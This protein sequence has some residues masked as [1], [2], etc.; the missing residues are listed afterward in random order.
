MSLIPYLIH[1]PLLLFFA[2]RVKR[3]YESGP[4]NKYYY[5]ALGLKIGAGIAL[6]FI[7][8]FYYNQPGDTFYLFDRSS[9]LASLFWKDPETFFKIFFFNS[10]YPICN[11]CNEDLIFG[12][13]I[14]KDPRT[15]FY[16]KLLTTVN[17]VSFNNYWV[18]SAYLSFFSFLGFFQLA[19]TLV[20][21]FNISRTAT[22]FSLLFF[23][24]VLIW[25]SGVMKESIVMGSMVFLISIVLRWLYSLEKPALKNLFYLFLFAFFMFKIKYYYFVILAPVLLSFSFVKIIQDRYEKIAS[26]GGLQL[27]LFFAVFIG[28]TSGVSRL[29]PNLHPDNFA[30]A[31][32]YSYHSMLDASRGWNTFHF[33]GLGP[34]FIHILQCFPQAVFT[35]LFRP[36]IWEVHNYFGLITAIENLIILTLSLISIGGFLRDVVS[37]RP[38][39]IK[40]EYTAMFVYVVL[41]AFIIPIASPNWG[42]LV[43]YKIGYLPFLLLLITVKNPFIDLISKK[44]YGRK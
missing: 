25:S 35:G 30:D 40:L 15:L 10:S 18:S 33:E 8:L 31:L 26:S 23:P 20:R 32:I 16:I 11:G 4:L 36:F 38:L 12:I 1:I 28:M 43:R 17:I 7:Y 29:H 21:I 6:G 27:I 2:F 42:S 9:Q 3:K 37:R 19:S 22:S 39:S 5:A 14:E 41:L 24:S 13:S 44:L 34:G